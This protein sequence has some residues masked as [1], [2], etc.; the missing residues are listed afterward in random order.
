MKKPILEYSI[1]RQCQYFNLYS[2]KH[3]AISS[4][5]LIESIQVIGSLSISMQAFFEVQD[6]SSITNISIPIIRILFRQLFKFLV[7]FL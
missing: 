5:V 1:S 3:F 7:S 2:S 4:G 6:D